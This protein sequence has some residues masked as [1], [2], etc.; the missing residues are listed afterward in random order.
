MK[1]TNRCW[2]Y[3]NDLIAPLLPGK[4]VSPWHIVKQGGE[5]KGPAIIEGQWHEDGSTYT[6]S[7]PY[8]LASAFLAMQRECAFAE[9][10]R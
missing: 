10:R 8:Q 5:G 4:L 9:A 7:V 2:K 1:T 6:F 3:H